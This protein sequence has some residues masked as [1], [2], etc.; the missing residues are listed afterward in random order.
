MLSALAEANVDTVGLEV[1]T[2]YTAPQVSDCI[3]V[4]VGTMTM[5]TAGSQI[6][7]YEAGAITQL[8]TVGMAIPVT[9]NCVNHDFSM[10]MLT[11]QPFIQMAS[12]KVSGWV[13]N[14]FTVRQVA[15]SLMAL[16]NSMV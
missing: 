6:G 5:T 2:S 7:I 10:A 12:I 3:K 8:A 9:P 1:T 15:N 16:L 4:A 11:Y 13:A 14:G